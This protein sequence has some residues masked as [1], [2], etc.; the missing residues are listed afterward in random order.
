MYVCVCVSVLSGYLSLCFVNSLVTMLFIWPAS[1]DTWER[2]REVT[3]KE[4]IVNKREILV[5]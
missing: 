3:V 5:F 1:T 2:E 4:V